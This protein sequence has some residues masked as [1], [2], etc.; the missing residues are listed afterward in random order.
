KPTY[1]RKM[2][3]YAIN[4]SI[5]ESTMRNIKDSSALLFVVDVKVNEHQIELAVKKLFDIDVSKVNTHHENWIPTE[6][7]KEE[8][9]D[10]RG[11]GKRRRRT[12]QGK[13]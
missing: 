12:N 11:G 4:K 6:V 9:E 2:D 5:Q 3:H 7:C 10:V 1:P 13:L 8:E